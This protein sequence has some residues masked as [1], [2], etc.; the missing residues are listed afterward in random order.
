MD[1]EILENHERYMD[2]KILFK[3]YGY[4]VDHERTFILE[5]ARP[6]YG[7]IL[8]VGTGKGH[9]TLVLAKEGC[10]F[11]SVDI[12]QEEQN[13]ARLNLAYYDMEKAVDLRI[14]NA[15]NLSFKDRHFDMIFSINTL[16]HLVNP[17]Q[18]IDGF[19]RVT[20]P[21]G[22]IILSDFNQE[23]LKLIDKIHALE[24]KTHEVSKITLTDIENYLEKKSFNTQRHTSKFQEVLIA[25][26]R[27]I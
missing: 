17:F 1:K 2:R 9:F 21:K 27:D 10:R 13:I 20:A 3:S 15:E 24:G 26:R 19:I 8:E 25:H 12:S 14:E 4:D 6:F 22:K 16:H 18:V 5:K 7:N 23:G 11:I